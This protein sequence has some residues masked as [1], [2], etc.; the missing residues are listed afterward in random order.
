MGSVLHSVLPATSTCSWV[1]HQ[2]S[3]LR[4]RTNRAIHT[5][6]RCA[7]ASSALSSH[8]IVS[9]W[10][11]LQKARRHHPL[12]WALTICR[13]TVSGSL[14]LPA[15]VLFSFRSRYWFTIGLSREYLALEMVV[16]DSR[17]ISR[18]LRYSGYIQ[19]RTK[20]RTTGLLPSVTDLS[21]S[22][23]LSFLCNS[24]SHVLQPQEASLLVWA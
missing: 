1:D 4:P 17:R 2:V 7:S 14:S 6:F 8:G 9:R 18:V 15:G 3:G 20:F 21:R 16:P 11:I 12:T 19:E 24:V 23:L 10:F 13:H 22:L 5:R